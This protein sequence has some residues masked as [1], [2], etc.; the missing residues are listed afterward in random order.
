MR[1]SAARGRTPL[2]S[3]VAGP[4]RAALRAT[5]DT[6]ARG[7]R[8]RRRR[9]RVALLR[10][11]A[12]GPRRSLG[13]RWT[14]VGLH[15]SLAARPPVAPQAPGGGRRARAGR[16]P[17]VGVLRP[18]PPAAAHT[19]LHGRL[20]Q[21]IPAQGAPHA[22]VAEALD[23][24]AV[25][26]PAVR[27]PRPRH[28][29]PPGPPDAGGRRREDGPVAAVRVHEEP[30]VGPERPLVGALHPG[31]PLRE[32]RVT[33]VVGPPVVFSGRVAARTGVSRPGVLRPWARVPTAGA[34]P[35]RVGSDA[36]GAH[37]TVLVPSARAPEA[38]PVRAARR[39]RDAEGLADVVDDVPRYSRR[40]QR[41]RG[42]PC[43]GGGPGQ[44]ALG[45]LPLWAQ[46]VPGVAG[47]TVDRRLRRP[48]AV[49][50][51]TRGPRG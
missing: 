15:S 6:G 26:P 1:V 12:P 44:G 46:G 10:G 19:V 51:R 8:G 48:N 2:V 49:L 25:T 18:P 17:P 16:V 47:R 31:A 4:R 42:R 37:E 38:L 14:R 9:L 27:P 35:A 43:R 28:P 30:P 32:D 3:L 5:R 13:E 45:P 41:G 23:T 34:V 22:R 50:N 24:P 21:V 36:D 33:R 40:G 29:V 39:L 20:A 11:G 7:W